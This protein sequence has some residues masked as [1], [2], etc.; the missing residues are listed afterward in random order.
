MATITVFI[1]SSSVGQGIET[2][3]AQIAAEHSS[4]Q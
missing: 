4:S 2:I 1:G 3:F